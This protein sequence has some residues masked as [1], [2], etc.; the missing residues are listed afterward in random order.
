MPMLR[1]DLQTPPSLHVR[2][3]ELMKLTLKSQR[4][5]FGALVACALLVTMGASCSSIPDDI[6]HDVGQVADA[7]RKLGKDVSDWGSELADGWNKSS[8][9]RKQGQ[10]KPWK[11]LC[12]GAK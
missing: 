1:I 3:G 11:I 12:Q 5:A 10:C 8:T 7:H 6:G 2:R 4:L 9:A